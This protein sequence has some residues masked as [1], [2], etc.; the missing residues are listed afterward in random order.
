MQAQP[1][2]DDGVEQ[3]GVAQLGQFDD[4]RAVAGRGDRQ[5]R[6]ADAAGAGERDQPTGAQQPPHLGP[7]PP[8]ADVAGL[9][10]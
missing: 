8:S 3:L 7:F 5:P 9:H 1:V 6:L 10:R 4:D 2:G